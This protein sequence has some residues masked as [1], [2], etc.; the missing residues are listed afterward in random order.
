MTHND[1][2]RCK[3]K[4]GISFSKKSISIILLGI[5]IVATG[6]FDLVY[7]GVVTTR[8]IAVPAFIFA[9]EITHGD[10][11]KKQVIFTFDGGSGLQSGK[12]ILE[13]LA[14]HHVKGTFFLT[15]KFVEKNADFVREIVSGGHEIFN[16]TYDHLHLPTLTDGEIVAELD[17]M[18]R[19]FTR[20]VSSTSRSMSASVAD[21][22][23]VSVSSKPFFRAPYGDRDERVADI[24]FKAGY[25]GVY[26]TV[27]ARDWE[28][29]T[30]ITAANVTHR[31]VSSLAPGDIYL[32]H[33]GD[34]ITGEILDDVF[35][36]IEKRGYKLVS[37]TQGI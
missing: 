26:W 30:G 18:D 23:A 10:T 34:N 22:T 35:T 9:R 31:I 5:I 13:V 25:H 12:K 27:D 32:M 37:L 3:S 6:I 2:A 4:A 29:S 7:H 16:H 15:G 8:P 1:S 14:N 28:E 11:S 24:A 33:I 20:I 36:T 21:A 17:K 19:I